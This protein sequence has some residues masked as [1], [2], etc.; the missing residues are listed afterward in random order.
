LLGFLAGKLC[1]FLQKAVDMASEI[2]TPIEKRGIT[3]T[4]LSGI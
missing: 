4:E 1:I 2:P 3:M